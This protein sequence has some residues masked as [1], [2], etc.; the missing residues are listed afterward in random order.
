MRL[1]DAA[2]IIMGLGITFGIH[3]TSSCFAPGGGYDL[4]ARLLA[5]YWGKYIPGART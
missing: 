2:A 3:S 5:R 4:N 1:R